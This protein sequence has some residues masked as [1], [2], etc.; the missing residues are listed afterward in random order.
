MKIVLTPGLE[1]YIAGKLEAGWSPQAIVERL[2]VENGNKPVISFKLIYQWLQTVRGERYRKHLVAKRSGW[3]YY[4]KGSTSTPIKDRVFIDE[5]PRIINGR[6]R[7]GDFECDVLGSLKR[8]SERITGVV[9]RKARYLDLK[10]VGRLGESMTAYQDMLRLHRAK[11]GTFDN[12]TENVRHRI[13][14]IPTYFCHAHAAWEKGT[15]ENTFQR[16][17]RFIPKKAALSAYSNED[18]SA[19]VDAM[20]DT[21]RKCLHW[22]TPKE[23][24]FNL[25]LELTFKQCCTS[26]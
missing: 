3:Q 21:P 8:E 22:K 4:R 10:K 1:M 12:G 18:I 5:R 7:V 19:I 2:R 25:S 24:F 11:S 16:L 14:G 9:D 17:R 23:V 15:V 13:L 20:N 6:A 26:G